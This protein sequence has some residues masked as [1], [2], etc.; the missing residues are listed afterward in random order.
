MVAAVGRSGT[1]SAGGSLLQ[2]LD[3]GLPVG[4]AAFDFFER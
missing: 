2:A 3:K 4:Q 1:S